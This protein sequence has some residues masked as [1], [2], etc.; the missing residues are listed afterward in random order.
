MTHSHNLF[1]APENY[2]G[3][4]FA[5][6][7]LG[8]S[9]GTI[10]SLVDKNELHAWK[11]QGGHRRISMQSIQD[12]KIRNNISFK[13]PEDT[14]HTNL[15]VLIV[16][17]DKITREILREI[18]ENVSIPV[19]CTAISSAME[20]LIDIASIQPHILITDIAM[21]GI[22]GFDLVRILRHNPLFEK[23]TI[24]I[25]SALTHNEISKRGGLP[26]GSIF[27]T[28]PVKVDWFN[29][30]FTGVMNSYFPKK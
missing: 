20:A 27:M 29:G 8:L 30:F 2:C 14:S 24:V 18:C 12:F 5:S 26:D 9:V 25:L 11:T 23:M 1:I 15:R 10:H 19:D 22:D 3:T 17:D 28:K 21:P 13:T 16:E 7:I 6:K 4:S